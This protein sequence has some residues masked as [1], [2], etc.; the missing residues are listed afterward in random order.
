MDPRL[1]L[2][3]FLALIVLCVSVKSIPVLLCLYAVCLTMAYLSKIDIGYFIKRTWVFVPIFSLFIAVPAVFG[4]FSPGEAIAGVKWF[5]LDLTVTRQGLLG[6]GMFVLRVLASVSFAVL[7]SI[8][9]RHYEI[10]KAIRAFR[11]PAIYVMTMGMCY[12]YIFLFIEIIERTYTAIKSR[13]GSRVHYKKG[14]RMVAWNIA[15]LWMRS[16]EMNEQV[17]AAMLARGY[18]GMHEQ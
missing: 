2:V 4:V 12:R 17:Y 8:T 14:Q 11:V 13:V 7:L 10:L 1:K 15:H 16:Y 5:G 9:T 6:A 3:I 18:R